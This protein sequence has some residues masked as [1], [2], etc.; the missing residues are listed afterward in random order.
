M[1][2]QI[3][4][5]L[6]GT[7]PVNLHVRLHGKVLPERLLEVIESQKLIIGL[8]EKVGAKRAAAGAWRNIA[9]VYTDMQDFEKA[10]AGPGHPRPRQPGAMHVTC[11]LYTSDAAD[12]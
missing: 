4:H 8:A 1:H 10:S 9:G 6:L 5:E 3:R 11:L 12:E 7:A 2:H